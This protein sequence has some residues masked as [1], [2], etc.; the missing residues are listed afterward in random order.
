M[1]SAASAP[2]VA[3]PHLRPGRGAP[4]SSPRPG[5]R[6]WVDLAWQ[7]VDGA[8]PRACLWLRGPEACAALPAPTD[9]GDGWWRLQALWEAPDA[10][11]GAELYLY[12][13]E[14]PQ[15][16]ETVT[17]YRAPLVRRAV[18]AAPVPVAPEMAPATVVA[19]DA[20]SHVV[21]PNVGLGPPTLAPFG[22]V[23][24]CNDHD[25]A[26]DEQVGLRAEPLDGG[27][28]LSAQRHSA[29]VRAEVFG[30]VAGASYEVTLEARQVE[31]ARPRLCLFDRAR[32]RCV[33][34]PSPA[35]QA[36][37]WA[38]YRATFQAPATPGG[39]GP[40]LYLYADAGQ[41]PTTTEYRGVAVRPIVEER[42]TMV[43]DLATPRATPA[44]AWSSSNPATYHVQVHDADGPFVLSLSD[45]WSPDWVVRG[46]P[47][48]AT[49]QQVRI[50]GYRNGWVIDARGDLDLTIA[51]GPA[52]LGRLGLLASAT[53]A[54]LVV[55]VASVASGL[56][57]RAGR[58][59]WRHRA[60][61]ARRPLVARAWWG[62]RR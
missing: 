6:Y 51:Y 1:A 34:L 47:D 33:D 5:D 23:G 43:S 59:R 60:I 45:A 46:L 44:Y 3:R 30:L 54:T 13:D 27:V 50:D 29:C 37:G 48:G 38:P 17:R 53:V 16:G 20:G 42:L 41:G 28:R 31:G 18:F 21:E 56:R 11:T 32:N 9:Q 7:K 12:A 8:A 52:R 36:G 57:Y 22:E 25:E 35:A 19:L 40:A 39:L 49:V 24:D 55:A 10:V 15:G 2:S 58:R 26:T 14:D 4:V 61:A 62:G